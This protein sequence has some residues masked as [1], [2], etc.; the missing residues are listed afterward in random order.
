ME[1]R[2]FIVTHRISTLIIDIEKKNLNFK[3]N[4]TRKL[5]KNLN[6]KIDSYIDTYVNLIIW[7]Y[8]IFRL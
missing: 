2:N 5:F 3:S 8:H 1:D 4:F 7:Q 6:S